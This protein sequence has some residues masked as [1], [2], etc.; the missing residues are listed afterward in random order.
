LVGLWN[1]YFRFVPLVTSCI[2]SFVNI[3]SVLW[4]YG[5][6]VDIYAHYPPQGPVLRSSA[7]Q[8][9]VGDLRVQASIFRCDASPLLGAT[10]MGQLQYRRLILY[11]LVLQCIC[12]WLY[13]L[14]FR[15]IKQPQ[16]RKEKIN[17]L[18]QKL[19][20]IVLPSAYW[21]ALSSGKD[22][23]Q[24]LLSGK[25]TCQCLLCPLRCYNISVQQTV[26]NVSNCG[27]KDPFMCH[28]T[29]QLNWNR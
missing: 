17:F 5:F 16:Q 21:I 28:Q 9:I 19:P 24:Y 7:T 1:F 18:L 12:N 26:C 10:T 3:P 15:L 22:N 13:I 27:K 11:I 29:K 4:I 14:N 8:T 20:Q 2:L 6:H 25:D 23:S